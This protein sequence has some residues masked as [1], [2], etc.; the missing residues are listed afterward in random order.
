MNRLVTFVFGL[1]F[2]VFFMPVKTQAQ[3]SPNLIVENG[4]VVAY[5]NGFIGESHQRYKI[6]SFIFHIG[7]R[8]HT[9]FPSFIPQTKGKLTLYL[10]PQY[11]VVD[12]PSGNYEIGV[13]VGF[14]YRFNLIKG[15]D[16]YVLLGSGLH[17]ISFDS[18]QQSGGF[19]FND[20]IGCGL[21]IFTSKDTAINIGFR[22]RHI[23]NANIRMPNEGIN[24]YL[25]TGGY[26]WFFQ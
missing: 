10:E 25:F 6:S 17:Y 5:G 8:A 7:L 13:G 12:K 24:S 23:S 21:Y 1:C 14:E 20:N 16:G 9:I 11:N 18:K 15:S 2:I 26:S 3:N 19:N 22:F 4:V